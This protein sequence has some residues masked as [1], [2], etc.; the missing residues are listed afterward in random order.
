MLVNSE[1]VH[2]RYWS[3]CLSIFAAARRLACAHAVL[4]LHRVLFFAL[5]RA[6]SASSLVAGSDW[7][8]LL[9][10]IPCGVLPN[11][12]ESESESESESR[13]SAECSASVRPLPPPP[14]PLSGGRDPHDVAPLTPGGC[15]GCRDAEPLRCNVPSRLLQPD[16]RRPHPG[17]RR[18]IFMSASRLHVCRSTCWAVGNSRQASLTDSIPAPK[19]P[20]THMVLGTHRLDYMHGFKGDRLSRIHSS[21]RPCDGSQCDA[22]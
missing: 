8:V 9:S 17:R 5:L 15:C 3:K 22:I 1:N 12:P 20:G 4:L 14:P 16:P 10:E 13:Q 18:C 19:V 7:L 21:W 11:A 2:H 6:K